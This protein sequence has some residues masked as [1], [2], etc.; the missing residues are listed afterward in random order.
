MTLPEISLLAL[1]YIVGALPIAYLVAQHTKGID[2]RRFGTGQVGGGNLWRMAGWQIGLPIIVFDIIKGALMFLAAR[3][4]GAAEGIQMTCG[5]LAI[6]GHNWSVFLKFHGGRGVATTAGLLLTVPLA[7]SNSLWPFLTLFIIAVGGLVIWRSTPLPVLI[8]LAACP[9]ASLIVGDTS[10]ATISYMTVLTIIIIKRL[11]VPNR[12]GAPA[13]KSR[14][15]FW[16]RLLFDRDI[17][18]RER[19]IY[20]KPENPP[21]EGG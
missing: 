11:T 16:R 17:T 8:G 18:D 3:E 4:A 9:V 21:T 20:H 7:S 15:L 14:Q 6:V 19:W 12:D 13:A 10:C 1:S 2:L 5:V